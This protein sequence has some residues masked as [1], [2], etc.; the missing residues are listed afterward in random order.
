ML[1]LERAANR[2]HL[3]EGSISSKRRCAK[4]SKKLLAKCAATHQGRQVACSEKIA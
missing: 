4:C 3:A 2:E 1:I